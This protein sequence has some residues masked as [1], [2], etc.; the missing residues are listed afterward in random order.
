MILFVSNGT[1]WAR[2]DIS[3]QCIGAVRLVCVSVLL[4]PRSTVA[5]TKI[6]LVNFFLSFSFHFVLVRI[7]V[8]VW[9]IAIESHA[10]IDGRIKCVIEIGKIWFGC[11]R[12]R[13]RSTSNNKTPIEY[14]YVA[15]YVRSVNTQIN[16]SSSSLFSS[17]FLSCHFSA[18]IDI[19][20][21]KKITTTRRQRQMNA[22]IYIYIYVFNCVERARRDAVAVAVVAANKND[23]KEDEIVAKTEPNCFRINLIMIMYGSVFICF[24]VRSLC[25]RMFVCVCVA[26][27]WVRTHRRDENIMLDE[28]VCARARQ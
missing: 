16:G 19:S 6:I 1:V 22:T 8:W 28:C 20:G 9:V 25:E 23:G 13:A 7:M 11:A 27:V 14:V 24:F 18:K 21:T 15:C 3:S 26:L 10:Y 5:Y 12:A 2:T 4:M 17:C